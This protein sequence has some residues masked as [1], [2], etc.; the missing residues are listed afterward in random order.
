MGEG[1]KFGFIGSESSTVFET[2]TN[3][4]TFRLCHNTPYHVTLVI[5]LKWSIELAIR[6]GHRNS[7]Q[8]VRWS[9]RRVVQVEDLLTDWARISGT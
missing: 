2:V 6:D 1:G 8:R 4:A 7:H 9:D 5:Q 3:K